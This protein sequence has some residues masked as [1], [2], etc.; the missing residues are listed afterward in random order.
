MLN[1]LKIAG[2]VLLI[3]AILGLGWKIYDAGVEAENA[4]QTIERLTEQ[5]DELN[6]IVDG[7][8]DSLQKKDIVI[9]SQRRIMDMQSFAIAERDKEVEEL[10]NRLDGLD[11]DSLG[12][13]LDDLAPESVRELFRRLGK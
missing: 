6:I 12:N 3:I 1:Q 8:E 5:V 7:L 10:R 11:V 9:E 4:R 13:D 2:I